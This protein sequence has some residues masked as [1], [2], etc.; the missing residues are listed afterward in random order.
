MKVPSAV[1][2]NDGFILW[3]TDEAGPLDIGV[4]YRRLASKYGIDAERIRRNRQPA[5]TG[6]EASETGA[7]D[8]RAEQPAQGEVTQLR[9]THASP[10]HLSVSHPR[11]GVEHL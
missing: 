2:P 9:F 3:P 5:E 10:R 11:G 6:A 7:Q 1:S 8:L 4:A